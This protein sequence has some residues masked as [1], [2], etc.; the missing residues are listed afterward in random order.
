MN[1]SANSHRLNPQ[2][3]QRRRLFIVAPVLPPKLDGIGDYTARLVSQLA[4]DYTDLEVTILTTE[5]GAGY[6]IPNGTVR[7]VFDSSRPESYRA[8]VQEVVS[9]DPDW[10]LV[11]YNPFGYGRRGLNLHLSHALKALKL[12]APRTK[13]ALMTHEGVVPLI[14]LKFAVM[15]TWQRYQYEVLAR[16]ADVMLFSIDPWAERQRKKMPRKPIYHLPVG[17][18]IERVEI[19]RAEA[20][21]RLGIAEDEC[22]LGVFGT[23]HV[24]RLFHIVRQ[25]AETLQKNGVKVRVLYVGPHAK[26][27]RESL[28]GIPLISDGPFPADEVS[29]RLAAMDIFL[30]TYID[31]VSTRRGALMAA[32]DHGL[33]VVGTRNYNTDAD[34]LKVDGLALH[35]VPTSEPEQFCQA[36]LSLAFNPAE[37]ERLGR[38]ARVLFQTRYDWPVMARRLI[39]ILGNHGHNS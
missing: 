21:T 16:A 30:A 33:A 36:V 9:G 24:S 2:A 11:Q 35:L 39:D 17:S 38:E 31:G 4:A 34:F 26:A 10:L 8:L 15:Y 28:Q 20:R 18:N 23:A 37:R 13:Q 22:V 6:S 5:K 29:R 7:P 14:S 19:S 25:A 27:V 1:D 3:F 32:L 12:A